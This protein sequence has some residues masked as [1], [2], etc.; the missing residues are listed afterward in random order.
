M[1]SADRAPAT[2][3]TTTR[4]PFRA[5]RG[6][7]A[8]RFARRKPLENRLARGNEHAT[9]KA[10]SF[11]RRSPGEPEGVRRAGKRAARRSAD[12]EAIGGPR[13]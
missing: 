5:G 11:Q 4:H 13:G 7:R 2:L 6:G 3:T 12:P 1:P 10:A 9:P 8:L